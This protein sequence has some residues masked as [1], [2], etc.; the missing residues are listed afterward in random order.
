MQSKVFLELD[1]IHKIEFQ[2]L[3]KFAKVCEENNLNSKI[4]LTEL[5]NTYEEN[6]I[7]ITK[8]FNEIEE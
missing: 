1:E 6:Y 7:A 4:I 2:M 8:I 3:Q 5:G